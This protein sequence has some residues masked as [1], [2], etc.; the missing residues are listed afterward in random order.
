L[1]SNADEKMLAV[2]YTEINP[3]YG[4]ELY[5]IGDWNFYKIDG[6][7]FEEVKTVNY[8]VITDG[9]YNTDYNKSTVIENSTEKPYKEFEEWLDSYEQELLFNSVGED[10]EASLET[11]LSK[12]Q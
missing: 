3:G 11:L 12:L 2:K 8:T 7:D 9:S 6:T 4:E 1:L 10:D 5:Y